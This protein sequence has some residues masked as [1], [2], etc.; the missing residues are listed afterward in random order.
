MPVKFNMFNNQ[1][2]IKGVFFVF[3]FYEFEIFCLLLATQE[4]NLL[5]NWSLEWTS[6][7]IKFYLKI[8]GQARIKLNNAFLFSGLYTEYI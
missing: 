5:C 2:L 8:S 3:V 1:I 7:A 4:E 6:F